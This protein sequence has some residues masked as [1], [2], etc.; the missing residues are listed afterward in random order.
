MRLRTKLYL[1]GVVVLLGVLS[2]VTTSAQWIGGFPLG[3]FRIKVTSSDGK[4]IEGATLRIYS[5]KT[6]KLASYFPIDNHVTGEELTTNK[7]GETVALRVNGGIDFGGHSW[8]LFWIIPMGDRSPKFNCVLSAAGFRDLKF[9]LGR[10][11][12][13]PHRY[14]E[15]F[16]KTTVEI[17]GELVE[18]K[19]YQQNFTMKR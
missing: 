2:Y 17:D 13:S 11:F 4:P 19:L 5:K 12:D 7:D 6:S 8:R 14:Y 10:L 15:D 9:P 1:S 18:V 3:E 16:P